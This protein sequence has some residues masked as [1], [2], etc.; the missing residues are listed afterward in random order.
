[1]IDKIKEIREKIKKEGGQNASS[2]L[3]D[4]QEALKNSRE[5]PSSDETDRKEKEATPIS[6]EELN[7]SDEEIALL[8]KSR[9]KLKK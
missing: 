5:S 3:S 8:L 4:F 2:P 9:K 1:M 6:L 7:L